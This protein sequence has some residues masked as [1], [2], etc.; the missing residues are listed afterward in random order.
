MIKIEGNSYA[1]TWDTLATVEFAE[2]MGFKYLDE[3]GSLMDLLGLNQDDDKRVSTQ[4]MK[5]LVHFA[6]TALKAGSSDFPL[7]FRELF[8]AMNKDEALTKALIST[9]M[10]EFVKDSTGPKGDEPGKEKAAGSQ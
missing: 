9:A 7:S 4:Q 6:H 3:V 5:N 10:A 1:V 8:N 2:V